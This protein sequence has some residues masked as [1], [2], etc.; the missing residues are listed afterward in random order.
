MRV[1]VLLPAFFI[2]QGYAE[3]VAIAKTVAAEDELDWT[4]FRVPHLNEGSADL[5]V[6]AGL[7]GPDHKG[8]L[9]LSRASQARWLLKEI[10]ERAWIKGAPLLGNY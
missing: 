4:I 1:W 5:P 7:L 3:M 6:W 10:E 2:P 9:E 8:S